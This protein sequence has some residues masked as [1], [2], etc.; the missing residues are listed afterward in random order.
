MVKVGDTL[1]SVE[2]AEGSPGNKVNLAKTLTG[3]GVIVGV[4][5]AF[6]TSPRL[7]PPF[8]AKDG[9]IMRSNPFVDSKESFVPVLNTFHADHGLLS[10]S[11]PSC[12]DKHIPG[13]INSGKLGSAGEV[14]VV[15]VNDAFVMNAWGKTLDPSGGKVSQIG[16]DGFCSSTPNFILKPLPF[17]LD[18]PL[19]VLGCCGWVAN[20]SSQVHFMADSSGAFTKALDLD[21]DASPLLGNARSKRYALK[22]DGGKVT[23]VHLE[24]DN[25]GVNG[26]S[27]QLL[28]NGEECPVTRYLDVVFIAGP[29]QSTLHRSLTAFLQSLLQRRSLRE[30]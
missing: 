1:P 16:R 9:P 17:K 8:C 19:A 15:S 13:Y 26:A 6:S 10:R 29:C 18:N 4:P 30:P 27:F 7:R 22:V 28:L 11:G 5:A 14:Y 2:L 21:F 25:T 3:K 20:E 12:S 24:P 23:S